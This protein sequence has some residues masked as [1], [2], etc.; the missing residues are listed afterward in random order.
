MVEPCF[1]NYYNSKLHP[2][3][4]CSEQCPDNH[5][6]HL[7]NLCVNTNVR[8]PESLCKQA[9]ESGLIDADSPRLRK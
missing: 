9:V 8:I 1:G 7:Y 3:E 5:S 2:Q 4:Y 6:C